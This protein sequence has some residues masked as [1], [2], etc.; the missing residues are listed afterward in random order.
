MDQLLSQLKKNNFRTMVTKQEKI[1]KVSNVEI[2]TA[3]NGNELYRIS[4][5]T[6]ISEKLDGIAN[7][8]NI[9]SFMLDANERTEFSVLMPVIDN[10]SAEKMLEILRGKDVNI[11]VFKSTIRD[12]S[13]NICERVRYKTNDGH[14]R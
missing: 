2:I 7:L 4:V 8:D 1:G 3:S 11:V 10:I 6:S 9:T 13:D 5:N 12:L 14:I